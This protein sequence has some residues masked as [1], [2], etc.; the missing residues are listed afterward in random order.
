MPGNGKESYTGAD[1]D[2]I[3]YYGKPVIPP[4]NNFGSARREVVNEMSAV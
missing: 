3:R 4:V 2:E 1:E